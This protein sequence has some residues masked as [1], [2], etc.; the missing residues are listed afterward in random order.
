M[1]LSLALA[2]NAIADLALVGGLAWFMT[3]PGQADPPY[4]PGAV[5]LAVVDRSRAPTRPR[6][7]GCWMRA[8]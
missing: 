8:A 6:R 1:T 7:L 4:A 3:R 2:L 5:R